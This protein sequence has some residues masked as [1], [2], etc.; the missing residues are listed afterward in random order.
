GELSA[1]AAAEVFGP[2]ET[3][4]IAELR[5]RVFERVPDSG[6]SY[7]ACGAEQVATLLRD[8]LVV[9][10]LNGPGEC[11]VSGSV[12][13]LAG[14]ERRLT[15]LGIDHRRIAVPGAVHSPLLDPFLDEYRA[16]VASFG[17]RPARLPLV[18]NVTGKR[19]TEAEATDP[20]YWAR[21]LRSTVLFDDCLE[22]AARNGAALVDAG[23]GQGLRSLAQGLAGRR[24]GVSAHAVMGGGRA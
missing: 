4:R 14:L 19:L 8:D 3:L 7:V 22:T 6:S 20:G 12:A 11:V 23:P 9:A 15:A 10:V 18:S 5:G 16:L 17:P 24:P 13:A 21:Q 1:A 2:A